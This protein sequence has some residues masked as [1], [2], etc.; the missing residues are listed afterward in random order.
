MFWRRCSAVRLIHEHLVIAIDEPVAG[1]DVDR[2]WRDRSLPYRT[3]QRQSVMVEAN[4]RRVVSIARNIRLGSSRLKPSAEDYG[5][6]AE[7][8]PSCDRFEDHVRPTWSW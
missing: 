6:A 1:A 3:R 8:P 2:K 5:L 7:S 4:S